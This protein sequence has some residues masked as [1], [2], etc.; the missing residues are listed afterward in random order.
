MSTARAITQVLK[1]HK[2]LKKKISVLE[3]E[4]AFALSSVEERYMTKQTDLNT[5]YEKVNNILRAFGYSDEQI[6]KLSEDVDTKT[7]TEN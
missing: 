3:E 7:A 2:I 5:E 4:K 1:S 6:V